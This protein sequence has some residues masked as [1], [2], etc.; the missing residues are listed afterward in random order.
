MLLNIG[1]SSSSLMI[2]DSN[3]AFIRNIPIA[4]DTITNQIAK[5]YG[6]SFAEA[7][8]MKLRH[9]FVAL[10]GAYEE[11]DS[12]L[13]ATISKISRNVMTRLHGEVSR[14]VNVWRAQHGGG[15][16][17]Q[18]LLSGGSS[19]MLYMSEFFQ[20]KLRIPVAYLNS[21][22]AIAIADEVDKEKLQ[23]VAP[24]C[25]ELIGTAFHSATYCPINI[26]LLPRSIRNQYEL[27]RRKPYFYASAGILPGCLLL[28]GF[29]VDQLLRRQLDRVGRVRNRVEETV[30]KEKA[31]AELMGQLNGSKGRWEEL[32]KIFRSRTAYASLLLELQKIMPDQMWLASIEPSDV[33][34]PEP[35][36]A[37]ATQSSDS[38]GGE[39]EQNSKQYSPEKERLRD[40]R[41]IKY[42]ILKGYALSV[43]N[44]LSPDKNKP[45]TENWLLK[46]RERLRK[47]SKFD[48]EGRLYTNKE[49]RKP[50]LTRFY[51]ILTLKTQLD[52]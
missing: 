46:F 34:P 26:S 23:N 42:L 40:Q 19:S 13:A 5:E 31:V 36:K 43:T 51:I 52:K 4:G 12:E 3:R 41:S 21:F 33:M 27:N 7:E 24:M 15:Q 9:G 39:G 8:Q 6:I 28:F 32:E 35:P 10:G 16:P 2:A 17:V 49:E 25:Q 29:G 45:R 30:K 47:S 48:G 14:S 1:S 11:P 20:E 37:G 18:V 22:G 44:N 38:E 50:G